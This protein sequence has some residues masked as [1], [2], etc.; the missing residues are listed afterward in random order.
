MILYKF[1]NKQYD[2]ACHISANDIIDA[3]EIRD[4][5]FK[6]YDVPASQIESKIVG[7]ESTNKPRGVVYNDFPPF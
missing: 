3:I 4:E 2:F 5:L 6:T 1:Y 7:T